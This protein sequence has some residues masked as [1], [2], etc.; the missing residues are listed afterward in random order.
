MEEN[1]P[2]QND[3]FKSEKNSSIYLSKYK[4]YALLLF[5]LTVVLFVSYYAY[6]FV[7][8]R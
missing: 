3:G 8:Y 2:E 1:I 6:I 7:K 4:I 5:V